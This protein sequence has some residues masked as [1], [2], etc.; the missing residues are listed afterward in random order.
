ML[1]HQLS[2]LKYLRIISRT[3]C[4]LYVAPSTLFL[5]YLHIISRTSCILYVA[6]SALF[7]KYLY[8]ISRT[9]GIHCNIIS[10]FEV[11]V[12]YQ[13]HSL[14]L[15]VQYQPNFLLLYLCQFVLNCLYSI[16]RTFCI[17]CTH[18]SPFGVFVQYQTYFLLFTVFIPVLSE[19][20]VQY[21]SYFLYLLYSY[22]F[23]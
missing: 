10:L 15:F 5:K 4:I 11:L 9:S 12:Q 6:P 17:D 21:Q 2:F 20:H 8:S 3:S 19:V 16:S 7:W 13:P 22:Q 18:T 1:R 23:L 14:F